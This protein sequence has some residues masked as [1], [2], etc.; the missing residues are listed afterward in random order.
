MRGAPLV[1]L[2]IG[3][4][5]CTLFPS[6]D[7]YSSDYGKTAGDAAVVDAPAFDA[8][9][10]D[11]PPG[12]ARADAG[13]D[14]D[15]GPIPCAQST[16]LFCEDFEN[17]LNGGVWQQTQMG[18][19]AVVDG[20]RPH[21]G[22]ASFHSRTNAV[23]GGSPNLAAVIKHYA[24][25]SFPAHFFVRHFLYAPSP[26]PSASGEQ[27]LSIQ[28][29]TSPYPGVGLGLTGGALQRSNWNVSPV[30]VATAPTQFPQDAWVCIESDVTVSPNGPMDVSVNG[31]TI[32][33]LHGD[34]PIPTLTILSIGA[35]FYPAASGQPAFDLWIDDIVIDTSPIGCDR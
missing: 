9:P 7:G 35:A 8:T 3:A 28:E 17:G 33:A 20:T 30:N 1:V 18:G 5:S 29:N 15:A 11:A 16:A 31:Q 10:S 23:A 25:P 26:L 21:R 6:F 2:G 19:T 14:A 27:F 34:A 24:S 22:A 12:D 32:S 4:S 13:A